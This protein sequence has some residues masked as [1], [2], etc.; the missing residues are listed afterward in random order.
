M[1]W[2]AVASERGPCHNIT[3]ILIACRLT[4]NGQ[5]DGF[6]QALTVRV[7]DAADTPLAGIA[8]NF[9]APAPGTGASAVLSA[10]IATFDGDGL[11]SIRTTANGI[12]GSYVVDA[13]GGG[14]STPDSFALENTILS[15]GVSLTMSPASPSPGSTPHL[16][17]HSDRRWHAGPRSCH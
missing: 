4:D 7:T 13:D 2:S 6:A 16:H 15:A 8:V 10:T 1:R 3:T 17:R 5:L 11:A 9:S 12:A 14:V